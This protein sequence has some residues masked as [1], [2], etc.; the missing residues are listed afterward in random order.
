M[1]IKLLGIEKKNNESF[2]TKTIS[3]MGRKS[4]KS[5]KN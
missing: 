1:N 3:E 4:L 5:K 2:Y